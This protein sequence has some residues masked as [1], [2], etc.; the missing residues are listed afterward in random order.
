MP[1]I[2]IYH[3][4]MDSPTN[5]KACRNIP[6]PKKKIKGESGFI[7]GVY[8]LCRSLFLLELSWPS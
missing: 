8:Q 6:F 5:S 2:V 7:L 3:D 1:S 4:M